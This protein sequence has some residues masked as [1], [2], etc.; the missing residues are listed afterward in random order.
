MESTF[1]A[2]IETLNAHPLTLQSVLDPYT[3]QSYTVL[4][5][6]W[7][8]VELFFLSLYDTSM[9]PQLPADIYAAQ[10]GNAAALTTLY[11]AELF[12]ED[13]ISRGMWYSVECAD[14]APFV[15]PQDMDKA[16]QTFAPAMRAADLFNLQTR[17]GI[18][19]FW[20]VQPAAAAE[21]QPVVSAMP[22]LLLEGEYDPITP[23]SNGDLAAQTLSHSEALLFPGTGHGVDFGPSACP[24]DIVL[25]F[26]APP[27]QTPDSRCIAAMGEP[28][29]T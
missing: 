25:A 22:T 29:F 1:Y 28:A 17:L 20:N 26:L 4:L 21:K 6:G 15:T 14:D 23:P 8:F 27:T 7:R 18:C 11:N 10:S 24:K 9:L 3:N 16:E 13:A 2:V 5:N 12:T 19:Q